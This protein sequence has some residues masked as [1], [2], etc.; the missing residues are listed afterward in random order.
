MV[1]ISATFCLRFV[2][3]LIDGVCFQ[4]IVMG[5]KSADFSIL[6]HQYSV[7]ILHRRNALCN[8]NLCCARYLRSKS[9]ADIGIGSRIHGTCRIVKNQ[10]FRFLQQCSC[11]TEALLLTAGNIGAAA[12]NPCLIA[13]WKPFNKFICR[14]LLASVFTFFFAGIS[15]TP[16]EIVE[17][18]ARKQNKA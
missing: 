11:N 3:F 18:R 13:V 16:T 8:D 15:F 4:Q 1:E 5:I 9:S 2:D 7:C 14:C 17:N 6:Q 12:L 10:N